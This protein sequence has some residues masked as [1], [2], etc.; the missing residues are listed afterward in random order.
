MDGKSKTKD[1]ST[2]ATSHAAS[3]RNHGLIQV[4]KAVA[5]LE[6]SAARH[7]AQIVST[8]KQQSSP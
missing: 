8:G 2:I 5:H 1:K 4:N 7:P 6:A 3:E